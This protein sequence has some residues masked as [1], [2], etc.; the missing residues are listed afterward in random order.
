V[1]PSLREIERSGA[2]ASREGMA[3]WN[4]RSPLVT[5]T[6]G[7]RR[8]GRVNPAETRQFVNEIAVEVVDMFVLRD[9]FQESQDAVVSGLVSSAVTRGKYVCARRRRGEENAS[10]YTATGGNTAWNLS[11]TP[12]LSE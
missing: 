2:T 6:I 8:G 7:R 10:L 5:Y 4:V 9:P 3:R 12:A 11:V 1:I